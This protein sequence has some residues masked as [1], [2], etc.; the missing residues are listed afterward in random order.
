MASRFE[1]RSLTDVPRFL[2]RSFAAWRQVTTAPGAYGA[3]LVARPF[4]R[5]FYTLSVWRD[6]D[7]LYAYARAEPHRTI[8]RELRSTTRDS[9]FAHWETTTDALPVLWDEAWR[10]LAEEAAPGGR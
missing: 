4:R 7:A 2:I 3:S 8:M 10:R 6:R 9:A 5:T 1:V